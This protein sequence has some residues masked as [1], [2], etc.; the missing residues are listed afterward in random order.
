M[1][2]AQWEAMMLIDEIAN[3]SA[4]HLS[5][6][7]ERRRAAHQQPH[8]LHSRSAYENYPERERASGAGLSD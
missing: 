8:V 4:F 7:M 1:S 5:M 6:V 3:N 2:A